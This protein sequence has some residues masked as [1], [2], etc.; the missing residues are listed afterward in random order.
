MHDQISNCINS[1][2]TLGDN[3]VSRLRAKSTITVFNIK[4][5]KSLSVHTQNL[6][7]LHANGESQ[8]I[9]FSNYKYSAVLETKKCLT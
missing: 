3:T 4:Y 5:Q 6:D 9:I 1:F 8:Q 7:I 2:K